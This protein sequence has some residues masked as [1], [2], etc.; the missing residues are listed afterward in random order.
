MHFLGLDPWKEG[1]GTVPGPACSASLNFRHCE[2]FSVELD[3]RSFPPH[4]ST[5]S[6][7]PSSC[8]N[9]HLSWPNGIM[10]TICLCLEFVSGPTPAVT[11]NIPLP[12]TLFAACL[13]L[14]NWPWPPWLLPGSGHKSMSQN[15]RG[16]RHTLTLIRVTAATSKM[17][18]T[19]PVR[20]YTNAVFFQSFRPIRRPSATV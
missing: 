11:H 7:C 10:E 8:I 16:G 17:S 12:R 1:P 15:Y 20:L 2:S 18:A 6:I 13:P 19:R 4:G 5:S 3:A 9:L 14:C